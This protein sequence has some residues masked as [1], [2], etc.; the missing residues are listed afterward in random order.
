MKYFFQ[1]KCRL[2]FTLTNKLTGNQL[3]KQFVFIKY[4]HSVDLSLKSSEN[5]EVFY[6]VM[7]TSNDEPT[8]DD[9][10][11]AKSIA[12]SSG[13]AKTIEISELTKGT[14]YKVYCIA[15]D[16]LENQSEVQ[17][18]EFTTTTVGVDY[19]NSA[20][21]T[22]YPNPTYGLFRVDSKDADI[23]QI[24]IMNING[25]TVQIISNDFDKEINLTEYE[26]QIFIV[27]ILTKKGLT[28][29]KIVKN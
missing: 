3:F 27:N 2:I 23:E 4:K 21:L 10:L 6:L 7:F 29:A 26:P 15:L 13:V 16:E 8:V 12:V 28:V 19:E 17:S 11:N 9:I 25:E 22:V 14:T 1:K 24:T 5:G 18:T 20:D